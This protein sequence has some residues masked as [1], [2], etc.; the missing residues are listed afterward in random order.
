MRGRDI[1]LTFDEALMLSFTSNFSKFHSEKG[2]ITG[3]IGNKVN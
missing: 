2:R 3:I 1:C